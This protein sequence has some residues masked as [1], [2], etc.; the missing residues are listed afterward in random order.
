M[1]WLAELGIQGEFQFQAVLDQGP[2]IMPTELGFCLL[3]LILCW[4]YAPQGA[5]STSR[6][7]PT[8]PGTETVYLRLGLDPSAGIIP[9]QNSVCDSPTWASTHMAGSQPKPVVPGF[10][11]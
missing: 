4:L 1:C 8:G 2:Q 11:T 6:F 10:R 5:P 3:V 9:G 7:S